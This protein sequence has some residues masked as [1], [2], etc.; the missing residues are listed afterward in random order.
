MELDEAFL[1]V[2]IAFDKLVAAGSAALVDGF[3]QYHANHQKEL[4]TIASAYH[5][6]AMQLYAAQQEAVQKDG[7][8]PARVQKP[9]E[10]VI[11]P[12]KGVS[13]RSMTDPAKDG[14]CIVRNPTLR[15]LRYPANA[16]MHHLNYAGTLTCATF[17]TLEARDVQAWQ[18]IADQMRVTLV[19][20]VRTKLLC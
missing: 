14:A 5:A 19:L 6:L 8:D 20:P 7:G 9:W 13:Q 4:P 15:I 16:V 3:K 10:V 11:Q 17:V 1:D 12:D 18:E 2:L